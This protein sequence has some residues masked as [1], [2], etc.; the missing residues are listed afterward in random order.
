MQRRPHWE[1]IVL[2]R[3][4]VGLPGKALPSGR[5]VRVPAMNLPRI[6]RAKLIWLSAALGTAFWLSD[7]SLHYLV[8]GEP[9]FELIP[10]D[11]NELWMRTVI[12]VLLVGFGAYAQFMLS[13]LATAQE[14]LREAH[15]R[16]RGAFSEASL[17]EEEERR[18][19]AFDLH[20]GI[21]QLLALAKIRLGLLRSSTQAHGLVREIGEV[22]ELLVE[23]RE[24][25]NSLTHQLSP[26]VL[27]EAGLPEAVRWLAED[28]HHRYGLCVT[29]D[30]DGQRGP[31]DAASR[32]SLFRC[33][34]ELLINV[35][36]Y[37]GT[38]EATV[39]F[40]A[41]EGFTVISVEDSG[42]GLAPGADR[43]GYGLFS[44]RDR[45]SH[46]GGTM[47]I[48]SLPGE[49]TKV[50]LTAPI[51]ASER[52]GSGAHPGSGERSLP[53]AARGG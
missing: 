9:S 39:R 3:L 31:L 22:E 1:C 25:S 41:E 53:P 13:R 45:M 21:G 32:I 44:V 34:S 40:R 12:V 23:A 50:I 10:T 33:L 30:A 6:M 15:D 26:P 51:R 19:L 35:A 43:S 14:Q 24:Q 16:L 11:P 5:V 17:A 52:E 8:Y 28:L 29:L 37:A 36:K 18:K 49:G 20:D 48:K 38:S 7:S 42:V 4:Q 27:Y 2:P 46:L 47:E